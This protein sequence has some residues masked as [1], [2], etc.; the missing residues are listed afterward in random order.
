MTN[1]DRDALKRSLGY[2][3]QDTV[4]V[5]NLPYKCEQADL[6][7]LFIDCGKVLEIRIP[8][9]R[10]TDMNRGY[11]F[12]TFETEK[13]AKKALNYNGHMFYKRKLNITIGETNKIMSRNLDQ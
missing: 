9:D 5:S 1:I 3:K 8:V 12:I 10:S 2:I 4:Y 11:G 13:A 7:N 6:R